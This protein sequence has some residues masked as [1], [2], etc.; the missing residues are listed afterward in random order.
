MMTASLAMMLVEDGRLALDDRVASHL[1]DSLVAGL[2]VYEGRS[3]GEEITVRQ[4]LN[5]TSGIMDDW[6]CGEFLDLVAGDPDRRWSPQETIKYVSDNCSPAFEPGGG[7]HY[8]DTGYNVLGL[9]LEDVTGMALEEMYREMLLSPLGMGHTYRPAY[10]SQRPSVPGRPPAERYLG[11]M[12]CTLWPSVM[13][14]DWAGGGLV[15]TARDLNRFLRAFVE[16]QIFDDPSSRAGMLDW[17]ESGPHN[18]YGLGVSRVLFERFEDPDVA[19]LGDVWGHAGSSNS[20]MYY[21]PQQ[22]VTMVGTMNQL[23]AENDL[24]DVVARIM[25][26]ILESRNQETP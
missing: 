26:T 13:T 16:D 4:L 24:Y 5:H 22:D 1:P 20:F 19:A 21:W 18:N 14:A 23:A 9:V 7:F 8:S 6:R 3:Y 10:E 2:H 25:Q 15:S 11:D 12:E 17:M